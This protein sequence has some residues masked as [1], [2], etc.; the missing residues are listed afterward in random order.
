MSDI[1]KV[2]SVQNCV[3][4]VS[5]L[6]CLSCAEAPEDCYQ[7]HLLKFLCAHIMCFMYCNLHKCDVE[8]ENLQGTYNEEGLLSEGQIVHPV[9]LLKLTIMA[10]SSFL[11]FL[12][13]MEV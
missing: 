2:P 12:L 8:T 6:G 4:L 11:D 9:K 10:H 5:L 3:F 7:I 1:L 13:M